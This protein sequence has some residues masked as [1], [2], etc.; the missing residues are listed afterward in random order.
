MFEAGK[1]LGLPYLPDVNSSS[2]DAS[3]CA[4]CYFTLNNGFRE[5]TYTAFLNP[6]IMRS[7]KS[8]LHVC[9]GT[10]VTR[11]DIQDVDGSPRAVGVYVRP[12]EGKTVSTH[13]SAKREVILCS[14]PF[15][16]PRLLQISGVGP[17]AH[18]DS[19]G[20]P[21]LKDLPGVGE[22]LQDHAAIYTVYNIPMHAS[23]VKYEKQPL[24]F[25]IEAI[26]YLVFGTG[27]LAC[28][29]IDINIFAN[30]QHLDSQC[31]FTATP[32]EQDSRDPKNLPDIEIMP[33][34]T[35][36]SGGSFD[37]TE[38]KFGTL[39]VLL[40]PKSTGSVRIQSS[41]PSD[42]LNIDLGTLSNPDDWIVLRT[43]VRLSAAIV[44]EMRVLGY[45][46][47]D[48]RVPADDSDAAIDE[49][50]RKYLRSTYHYSSTCRMAPEDD[51][52]PGVV[53][54]ELKV[55]GVQGLR[56][57][58]SS[59]FPQIPAT[60]LQAPAVMVAEKCADLIKATW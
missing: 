15:E 2:T 21:V 41:N 36:P 43:A 52:K 3:G 12:A 1:R 31:H 22:H 17:A 50:I 10:I 27:L 47:T 33:T 14:G 54:D 38:G 11:L 13:V 59:I 55:H 30:S 20:I 6:S 32:E 18:L 23:L 48:Y 35:D 9:T 24:G 4:K 28:P 57:A 39:S 7:R 16:N 25:I 40:R 58:D 44:K 26:K 19:L 34:P 49:H 51:E 46:S 60:H 42:P 29:V 8:N 45:P 53:D 5:S 56:V 37:R